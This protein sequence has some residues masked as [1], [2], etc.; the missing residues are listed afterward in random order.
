V[1]KGRGCYPG[2][3]IS[4]TSRLPYLSAHCTKFVSQRLKAGGIPMVDA[5]WRPYWDK[6]DW[7]YC[8]HGSDAFDSGLKANPGFYVPRGRQ[9]LEKSRS[10]LPEA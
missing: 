2:E 1:G 9:M 6:D 3:I 5:W 8:R 4:A 7:C 10:P